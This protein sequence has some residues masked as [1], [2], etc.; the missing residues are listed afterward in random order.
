MKSLLKSA[1]AEVKRQEV[2]KATPEEVTTG[3]S[4][5]LQAGVRRKV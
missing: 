5:E 2:G 3:Q 1:K 4:L